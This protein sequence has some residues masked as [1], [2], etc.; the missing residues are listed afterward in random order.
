MDC[1]D[2]SAV[3]TFC[4]VAY[5][6]NFHWGVSFNDIWW[7]FVFGLRSLWSHN[8]TSYSCFQTNVL[9]KFV[10]IIGIFFYTH[11]PYFCKKSSPIHFSYDQVFVKYQAQGG[12]LTPTPTPLAYALAFAT[13]WRGSLEDTLSWITVY[14]SQV[15][16]L[17]LRTGCWNRPSSA[18]QSLTD[19]T[20]S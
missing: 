9:W 19:V 10:D 12:V 16:V 20:K 1:A 14:F 7:W 5:T 4:T 13:P 17:R 15:A 11:S 3:A 6:E 2:T 8:L 18:L